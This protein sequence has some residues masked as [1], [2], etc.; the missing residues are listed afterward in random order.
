MRKGGGYQNIQFTIYNFFRQCAVSI[1]DA[2][3]PLFRYD[4]RHIFNSKKIHQGG[5]CEH[6]SLGFP[7]VSKGLVT[8]V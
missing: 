7:K 6:R 1:H 5:I 2:V 4:F 8:N 3:I